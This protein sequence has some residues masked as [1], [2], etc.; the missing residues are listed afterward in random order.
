MQK[1][2]DILGLFFIFY[3][4]LKL[5]KLRIGIL[6][7]LELSGCHTLPLII[8]M[9]FTTLALVELIKCMNPLMVYKELEK[10]NE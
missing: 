2:I 9:F 4:K 8:V 5:K 7:L 6:C 10:V 1:N 3:T